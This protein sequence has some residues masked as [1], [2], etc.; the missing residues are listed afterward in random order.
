MIPILMYAKVSCRG[1]LPAR[2]TGPG[3]AEPRCAMNPSSAATPPQHAC[4]LP[5]LAALHTGLQGHWPLFD[6]DE[7]GQRDYGVWEGAGGGMQSDSVWAPGICA[8]MPAAPSAPPLPRHAA[9]FVVTVAAAVGAVR[10]LYESWSSGFTLFAG[11][12]Y[13]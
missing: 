2:H 8:A 10:S 11:C 6:S 3:P 9:Q 12:E 4:A 7:I 13:S 1:A 5:W